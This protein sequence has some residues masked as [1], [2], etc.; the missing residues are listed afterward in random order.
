MQSVWDLEHL[1]C[2]TACR[3]CGKWAPKSVVFNA[4]DAAA[5]GQ[6]VWRK[7]PGGGAFAGT[8]RQLAHSQAPKPKGLSSK[9][10]EEGNAEDTF[11]VDA[12][13]GMATALGARAGESQGTSGCVRC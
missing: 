8:G 11:T 4:T 13:R 1:A 5:G 6:H 9:P 2:R 3:K 12:R 10:E 7:P